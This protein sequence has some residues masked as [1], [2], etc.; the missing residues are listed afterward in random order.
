MQAPWAAWQVHQTGTAIS[1]GTSNASSSREPS[2]GEPEPKDTV[3]HAGG[4]DTRRPSTDGSRGKRSPK[5]EA[6]FMLYQQRLCDRYRVG[7]QADRLVQIVDRYMPK[8]ANE[9]R[10]YVMCYPYQVNA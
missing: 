1:A 10:A 6:D 7:E 5:D 9:N 3:C 2:R 8:V 4:G